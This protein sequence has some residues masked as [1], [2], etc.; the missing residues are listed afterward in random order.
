MNIAS[1]LLPKDE[2]A[3]LRDDMRGRKENHGEIRDPAEN[4]PCPNDLEKHKSPLKRI[5]NEHHPKDH[6]LPE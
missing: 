6:L 1:F 4:Q 2:V 3:Y 5:D